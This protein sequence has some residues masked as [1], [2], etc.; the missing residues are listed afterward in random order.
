MFVS[1][2]TYTPARG[3][4]AAAEIHA[5]RDAFGEQAK[6][7]IIANTKGFTGHTMGVGVE[8]VVAVKA[9]EY[10]LVPPIA[11]IQEGFEPDP[12]LGDLNLS[13]GGEYP[14]QFSLRLGAGFGSQIAMTLLRKIPGQ[15]ERVDQPTY[16]R[17][18]AEVSGYPTTELEISKR[19][20][21]IKDQGVP[22]QKPAAS[23]WQYGQGP[24]LWAGATETIAPIQRQQAAVQPATTQT[25]EPKPQSVKSTATTGSEEIKKTILALVSEKTGYPADVL[26]LELD[27]EADLGIDTVKQAELFADIRSRYNIPRREDLRLAD[28]NTLA[29]VIAFVEEA[30]QPDNSKA[31]PEAAA[32]LIE[33]TASAE[34]PVQLAFSLSDEEIKAYVLTAVSQKTGY[35]A[36][37]LDLELDLEADLGI[38]TVK[39]AE[40]FAEIRGEYNIPRRED[41]R[42]ADYNTLAKVIAFVKEAIG[43][44]A[45]S[46]DSPTSPQACTPEPA[47]V[48]LQATKLPLQESNQPQTLVDVPNAPISATLD[49]IKATVLAAVSEKTGYPAEV[50]D[51]DL[52]LEADRG[53]DTVKQAELFAEIRGQYNIPQRE[54]LRLADYNT[55]AKVIRFVDEAVH[56]AAPVQKAEAVASVPATETSGQKAEESANV[57]EFSIEEIKT[58]LLG[59]VSEKTGYP[60]E[61]LDL[62]LDLEA[63]L[64]I[65]TVKQAELF[66]AIRGQYG[67]PRREDLR[68]ADYNTLA[69]VMAYVEI[70]LK[71]RKSA[72]KKETTAQPVPA[73]STD[74]G[75]KAEANIIVRRAPQPYLRPQLDLCLPTGVELA[76]GMRVLVVE[77]HPKNGEALRRKL[78]ARKV[79]VLRLEAGL[80][81]E[82]LTGKIN[83]MQ[84][85][86]PIAG[87]YF[88]PALDI[89]TPLSKMS[90]SEWQS[91]LETR[92]Y[93]LFS[94]MKA[95]PEE[96]FLVCATRMGG[97]HGYSKE[98]A[99]AP[100][101]GAVSGFA[102]ALAREREKAFVKVVDFE[103]QASATVIAG[104]LIEETLRDA[105]ALE[106]GW[107][108]NLRYGIATV[109]EPLPEEKNFTLEKGNVFLI[110]GGAGG[111]I[112]PI[113]EDLVNATQGTFYLL[114]RAPLP[115]AN[116]PDVTRLS[117]DR[118]GLKNDLISR[119]TKDGKKPTPVQVEG[120][121]FGIERSATTL[122]TLSAIEKHGGK[123]HYLACD[124]TDP[125][126]IEKAIQTVKEA[127]GHIDVFL[128]AAGLE[129]SR[130]LE[131]K[132][133]EE[134]RLVVSVKANGF[135]NLFKAMESQGILPRAMLF[136]TSVAGRFGN[137]GQTDYSAANDLLCKI[138][139]GMRSLYPG[140]KAVTIDWSAWGGVGMASRG[141]IPT[142]MKMAGI[143]MVPPEQA[144]PMVRAELQ[145][146]T[147]EAVIAGSLGALLEPRAP[148]GGMDLEKANQALRAGTPIHTMLSH[149]ADFD[150]EGGLV[151]EAE[152][153]PKDEPFLHDH[154]MNG[155]PVLPGVMGIEGFS[156]A[157]KHIGSVLASSEKDL[158]VAKLED[159]HFLAAFKFYRNEPRRVTWIVK[160]VREAEGLVVHVTLESTRTTKLHAG[161][162]MRHFTGKVHLVK[163]AAEM[164]EVKAETPK[165][166]G[167]LTVKAEDIYRLYFHGPA[168]QV[169]EG[170]QLSG[171]TVV[172]RLNKNLPSI[173]HTE[174]ALVS[175]PTLVELC[176]QTAGIWEIGK[177]GTMGLPR[178]IESL[179][180]YRQSI[181]GAQ[182]YAE[183]KP[184]ETKNEGLHFDAR[185]VDS[186]GRLYLELKDYRTTPLPVPVE[187]SLLKPL[188]ELVK[189]G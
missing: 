21:H 146:G 128:H 148:H 68:L 171:A 25:V 167:N 10:G 71:K 121:L 179:T 163:K 101:G 32:Q 17:W 149:V 110:S 47:I 155:I 60:T 75:I 74:L 23:R 126:Q 124:V 11:N 189:E 103:S 56:E 90:A 19:T 44:T 123:A 175:T 88:L 70:E 14:V 48:P 113:V 184:V 132:P 99:C 46:P 41:L 65:D 116:D 4:S 107:E 30:L 87:V 133:L 154:T 36:E 55:L 166:N 93:S 15:G 152:L 145:A 73:V 137:S 8:D 92:L 57:T 104:R 26:D 178:S 38:D 100:M 161:E 6:R 82:A 180:L 176:F 3:G 183:V 9:L 86:G 77:S 182:I 174:H 43:Q 130:K 49:D 58:Y 53:V 125:Q 85:E 20:L 98:G 61:V 105:G 120:A 117:S 141:N 147:G 109:E 66:T 157:A 78:S 138:A 72:S 91:A 129:R 24:T 118:E 79:E 33:P 84:A 134:F 67:L 188:Q 54:D 80:E 170:V 7:V 13:R 136:F 162:R 131:M 102:K 144:A 97:L 168:F 28:Y 108:K 76:E 114:D 42:L 119:M 142:L 150:L 156:I 35:P 34:N 135:F 27:L 64:G 122:Q 2:E 177:T 185:V 5:L 160:A 39:Q 52:D 127:E 172:G 151:L 187:K 169:L 165:W 115:E 37:V 158:E 139:Y 16:H 143:D 81:A 181:N 186:R 12:E 31:V 45:V 50:L 140:V 40:L 51:L 29:K 83:A 22:A 164:E 63:D 18:L 59:L 95:L 94:I 111:I 159:I 112:R 89:E 62:N 1:H 106:I 69:K 153:D 96:T 173:L